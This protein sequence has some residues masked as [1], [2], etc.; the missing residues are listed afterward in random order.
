[1]D[2]E[3]PAALLLARRACDADDPRRPGALA[4]AP[5]P[6]LGPAALDLENVEIPVEE[7]AAEI[8]A[9]DEALGKLGEVDGELAQL[10]EWRFFAGLSVEEIAEMSGRSERTVKRHWQA[11]RAF[12]FQEL[13]TDSG[14]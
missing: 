10:V 7:R 14:S 3:G 6:R 9:L 13:S 4:H 5:A 1:M 12:L 8:V 2:G 11:A